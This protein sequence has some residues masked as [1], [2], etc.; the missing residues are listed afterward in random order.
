[1]P[2]SISQEIEQVL[3]TGLGDVSLRELLGL[4]L[5]GLG[6]ADRKAYLRRSS[7]DKANGFYERSL[8]VGSLPVEMRVP[9]TRSGEFRPSSLPGHC[10]RGYPEESQALLLGLLG[11]SRSLSAAKDALRRM[12]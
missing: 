12:G 11:S 5:S 9:R 3:Q 6:L 10:E 1:V 8:L 4:M 7:A 2:R